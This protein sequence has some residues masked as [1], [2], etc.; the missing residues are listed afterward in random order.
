MFIS[1]VNKIIKSNGVKQNKNMKILASKLFLILIVVMVLFPVVVAAQSTAVN[2]CSMEAVK[3]ATNRMSMLP[4]CINQIYV[5]ALGIS[6]LLG[7]LM[8]IIGGYYKITAGGN[9]EQSTKGTE[10]IWAAIIGIALLFG[11]YL[12]LNT[13]NPQLTSLQITSGFCYDA[14]SNITS[15]ENETDCTASGGKWSAPF[16]APKAPE[17][18]RK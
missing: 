7:V 10:M 12:L 1:K 16:D 15:A 17:A 6:G 18:P 8:V 2:P 9:A 5:W 14:T 11:A 3:G 4:K 13:I